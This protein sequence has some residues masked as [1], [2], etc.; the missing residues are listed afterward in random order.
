M[1]PFSYVQALFRHLIAQRVRFLDFDDLAFPPDAD[2]SRRDGLESAFRQ[3]WR[4]YRRQRR[5]AAE[6]DILLMHDCDAG[7]AETVRMCALEAELGM[8]STT[9]LFAHWRRGTRRLA[10]P[11]DFAAMKRL[12]DEAGICVTYH[13]NAFY[14]ADGD[15]EL[16]RRIF[17]DDIR[18]LEEKGLAIRHFSAHGSQQY[19]DNTIYWPALIDRRLIWTHNGMSP[20]GA[21][22]SDSAL[23][24]SLARGSPSPDL[25]RFLAVELARSNRLFVHMH[26]QY[27]F[28]ETADA[29]EPYFAE[30]RWLET[31][32]NHHARGSM[33]EYWAPLRVRDVTLAGWLR[34][35]GTERRWRRGLKRFRTI[36]TAP[37]PPA[38]NPPSGE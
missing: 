29:A 27:Y 16:A 13:C 12:Q 19:G 15:P 23:P 38:G 4:D 25:K 26:P 31:V 36:P 30:N 20:V 34:R 28:D 37:S 22:Y 18:F 21:V 33:D 2:L 7:P 9:A 6:C 11:I 3:E 8:T 5:G 35:L 24:R 17:E 14:N 32:W 10:Y 1:L